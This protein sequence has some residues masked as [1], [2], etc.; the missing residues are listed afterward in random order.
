MRIFSPL[1]KIN[2][3]TSKFFE[4]TRKHERNFEMLHE[5]VLLFFMT[6]II[7]LKTFHR[8]KELEIREYRYL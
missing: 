3:F 8:I 7:L 1:I 4:N 6:D 2:F 5:H